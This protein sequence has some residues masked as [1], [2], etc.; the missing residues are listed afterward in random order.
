M[1][2][3]VNAITV[4]YEKDGWSAR[5]GQR[6]RSQYI[7]QARGVWVN[8]TLVAINSER[9][10]DSQF[11]YAWE[12]GPMKGVSID[13]QI[14]NLTNAP[15]RTQLNDDSYTSA[16]GANLL[17]PAIWNQYGRRYLL[18]LGYKF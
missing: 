6:Y 17:M 2:G 4:Y 13:F 16:T 18:G 7:A 14:G 11:G 8:T 12:S 3:D 15:Y 9:I 5:L 1:S 10:T